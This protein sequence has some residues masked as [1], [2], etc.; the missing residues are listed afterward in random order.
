MI[1]ETRP[2]DP[3]TLDLVSR[4]NAELTALYDH[5]DANHFSLA[6]DEVTGDRGAMITARLDG[7]CVALIQ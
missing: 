2:G 1:H 4:S 5:P 6:D 7:M 3:A